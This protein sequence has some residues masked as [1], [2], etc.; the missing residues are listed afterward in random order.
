MWLFSPNV[1]PI[2]EKV[3][4]T[5]Q[6]ISSDSVFD[7]HEFAMRVNNGKTWLFGCLTNFTGEAYFQETSQRNKEDSKEKM[8]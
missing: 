5:S 1:Q 3:K 8:E 6:E 7:F 2:K 4:E